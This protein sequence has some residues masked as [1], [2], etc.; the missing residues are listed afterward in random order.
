MLPSSQ[1]EIKRK[2]HSVTHRRGL[3]KSSQINY[4]DSINRLFDYILELISVIYFFFFT[5]RFGQNLCWLNFNI[6]PFVWK[7][8]IIV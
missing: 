5:V 8:S 4:Y 2:T 1:I 7:A 6:Q 3:N